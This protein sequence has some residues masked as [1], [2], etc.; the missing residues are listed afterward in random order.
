MYDFITQLM[1]FDC[2]MFECLI[3]NVNI[4]RLKKAA[5]MVLPS[6]DKNGKQFVILINKSKKFMICIFQKVNNIYKCNFE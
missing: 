6:R 4:V 3:I 5:H 1:Y 2:K